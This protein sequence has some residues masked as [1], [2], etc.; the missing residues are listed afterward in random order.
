MDN[1]MWKQINNYNYEASNDGKIKNI[2]TGRILK[3]RVDPISNYF[4][5]DIKINKK[6]VTYRTHR[7][8]AEAFLDCSDRNLWV[9]HIN[10]IRND[11][12]VENLRWVTPS[13]NNKNR[14]SVNDKTIEDIV[15]LCK[16]GF[17]I[18]EISKIINS[19]I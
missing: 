18:K 2:K 6:N 5:V 14:N 13:E 17:C 7:L 12:R 10:R 1:I 16:Q 15:N 9:D 11:N 4:L 19:K 8:I 3:Q